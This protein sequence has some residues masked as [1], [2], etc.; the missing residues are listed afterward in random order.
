MVLPDSRISDIVPD[1]ATFR[2]LDFVSLGIF[3]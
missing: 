2:V 1:D 3:G